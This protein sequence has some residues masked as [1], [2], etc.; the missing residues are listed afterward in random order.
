LLPGSNERAALSPRRRHVTVRVDANDSLSFLQVDTRGPMKAKQ[1]V[2]LLFLVILLTMILV[3][4]LSS[5]RV[6]LWNSFNEFS[7]LHSPWAVSTLFDA[8]CGFLTFY[9]WVAYKEK[10]A[11]AKVIWFVLI[12]AL[13]N[14]AMASY[15]LL[16]LSRLKPGDGI[17]N[18]VVRTHAS[19]S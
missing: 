1:G 10:T 2:A 5:L 8:Y 17:E 16:Q 19:H 9:V 14:I 15:V 13:G 12:M 4:S 3:T 6:P 7:W 18:L 11:F